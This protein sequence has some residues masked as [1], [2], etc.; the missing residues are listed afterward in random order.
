[1]MTVIW[2]VFKESKTK[3]ETKRNENNRQSLYFR[4]WRLCTCNIH[5]EP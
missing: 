1:M 3:T 5:S 2:I 4:H